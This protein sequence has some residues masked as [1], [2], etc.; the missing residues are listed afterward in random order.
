MQGPRA[1]AARRLGSLKMRTLAP[2]TKLVVASHN[3]GK[4]WEIRKLIAPYGLDAVS[5]GDLGLPEPEETEPTFAGNARLKALA[6]ARGAN[7]PALA[8][9][10]GL[11]V[12][13]L[14]GAPG[15]YSA[16]W[17]GPSK[18]FGLAMKTVAEEVSARH[19]W[20][21]PGPS[22]NFI[23]VLSL[24]WPDGTTVEFEGKVDGVL[25]WPARGGNGF[26]YDPMFQ[27]DGW[28]IT[29]GEM[30]PKAKNAMSHR[31]RAFATFERECLGPVLAGVAA[32]PLPSAFDGLDAAA[33]SISSREEFVRFL[34][35]LREDLKTNGAAWEHTTLEGYL[36]AL[37]GW[38]TDGAIPDEPVW[39]TMARAL[40]AASRYE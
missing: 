28:T 12:A 9:D 1:R 26:G 19:G 35:A 8:D 4:V 18:D 20:V 2:G 27:P 30:D 38:V 21:H 36:D 22:A 11:E 23:S 17:A 31:A 6:A 7:L 14:G 32:S 33:R 34:A 39:R 40:L 25:V 10:S 3:P 13:C 29:F 24:A 5:A 16:R 15:I 37:G